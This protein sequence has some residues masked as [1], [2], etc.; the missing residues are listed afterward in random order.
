[1]LDPDTLGDARR[2]LEICNAC[3]YCE[4]F[5]AVFPAME[6]RRAFSDGELMHLANLCHDCRG[7]YYACQYAPPHPFAINLPPVFARLRAQTWQTCAWPSPRLAGG[8]AG[9]IVLA[10]LACLLLVA[11]LSGSAMLGGADSRPGAFYR[12]LPLSVMLWLG[13]LSFLLALLGLAGG[14][15]RYWRRAGGGKF[16]WPAVKDALADIL[17]LRNLGRPHGC[18]DT[19]DA[20]SHRRRWFHHGLFYGMASCFAATTV[21]TIA[22][23]GLGWQPPYPL[24]SLPVILG[25]LGGV[26]ML[27]GAGGL[28]WIRV[29]ADQIPAERS[30][31]PASAAM[32][33]LLALVAASGLLLLGLRDTAAMGVLLV[34]HLGLVLALFLA[35]PY[36]RLVHGLYRAAA[37]L[38]DTM[39]R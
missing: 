21:A 16:A 39:E 2:F 28:F 8:G 29:S 35:F 3:R 1:M 19:D 33:A 20:F 36:T 15:V 32:L 13:G 22:E 6:R 12:V 34:I 31:L 5:C 26:A 38:R 17:T 11:G 24:Y 27:V 30:H 4:G 10:V 37:L 25:S 23:H 14:A 7:C 9:V 18:N